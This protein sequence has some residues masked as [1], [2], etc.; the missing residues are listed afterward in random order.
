[1]AT[2]IRDLYLLLHTRFYL[3]KEEEEGE[4]ERK[5]REM[6]MEE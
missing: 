3:L 4:E 1:V 5:E 6:E 2:E